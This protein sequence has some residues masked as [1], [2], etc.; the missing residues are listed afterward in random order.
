MLIRVYDC[1]CIDIPVHSYLLCIH[2]KPDVEKIIKTQGE[3]KFEEQKANGN[4]L[5]VRG[6]LVFQTL[7]I[8]EE[9]SHP[10]HSMN[11]QIPFDET[12]HMETDCNQDEVTIRVELEDLS[13]GLINSRKCFLLFKFYFTLSLNNFLYI[14]FRVRNIKVIF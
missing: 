1:L 10:I 9:H 13:S 11:A 12:I 3:V 14:R 8:S 7:Y 2:S 4:K 6:A 5:H